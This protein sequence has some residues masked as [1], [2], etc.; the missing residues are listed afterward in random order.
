MHAHVCNAFMCMCMYMCMRMDVCVNGCVHP[1]LWV[2]VCIF[3][4]LHTHTSPGA[5]TG[6]W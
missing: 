5:P 6:T 1:C 4:S 2:H 3:I